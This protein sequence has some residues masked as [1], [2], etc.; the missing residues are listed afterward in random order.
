MKTADKPMRRQELPHYQ[1]RFCGCDERRGVAD[2]RPCA[3]V[4]TVRVR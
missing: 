1:P 3:A 4:G 2:Q